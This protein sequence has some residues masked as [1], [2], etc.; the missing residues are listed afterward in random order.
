MK[1]EEIDSLVDLNQL[2]KEAAI[3]WFQQTCSAS[4]WCESME[5]ARPFADVVSLLNTASQIWQSCSTQDYL[6]AFEAHPMIGDVNSLREK[7]KST[8]AMASHEQSGAQSASEEVLQALHK[9]NL[10]YVK[11]HGFIFIIFATGK[12]AQDMLNALKARIDND[13][14]TEI[15]NAAAEQIKIT[16]LRLTKNLENPVATAINGEQPS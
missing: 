3:N 1:L 15:Q 9:Y 13:T 8:Q 11:K 2:N 10:D 14:E 5:K 4:T 16:R 12:S 6:Q 7:F